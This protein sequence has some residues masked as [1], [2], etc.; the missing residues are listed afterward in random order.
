MCS[1]RQEPNVGQQDDRTAAGGVLVSDFDGTL[2][3]HDF[4]RLALERLVPPGVP[5]YWADY[6][7]GRLTHFEAMRAYYGAIRASEADTLAVVEALELEPDLAQWVKRLQQAGWDLV[8]AS[9]GCAW[10]IR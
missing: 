9:A 4:F 5:D 10:Y 1:R 7:A 8:V 2:T 3:H 6:R